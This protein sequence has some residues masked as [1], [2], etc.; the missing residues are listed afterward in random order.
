MKYFSNIIMFIIFILFIAMLWL[1][2]ENKSLKKKNQMVNNQLSQQVAINSHYQYR[3]EQLN[4]MDNQHIQEITNAKN[5]IDRLRLLA[6]RS[7]ERVYINAKCPKNA[8]NSAT[9]VDDAITAR[10]SD[11]AIRN[12]WLLRERIAL[13]KQMIQG[14]QDYINTE[15]LSKNEFKL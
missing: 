4:R 3:V 14:L 8:D 6:E 10:A 1:V 15:C 7:P 12:Y 5:E 9:R 13:S 2:K 11:T